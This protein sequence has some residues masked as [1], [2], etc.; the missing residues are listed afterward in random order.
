MVNW[1]PEDNDEFGGS[2]LESFLFLALGVILV[3]ILFLGAA[4]IT[5]FALQYPVVWVIVAGIALWTWWWVN[6]PKF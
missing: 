3:V 4:V 5:M 6:K 1:E 2:S